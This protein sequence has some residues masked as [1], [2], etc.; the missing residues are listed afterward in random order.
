MQP[1]PSLSPIVKLTS[2][3]GPKP[4]RAVLPE[5]Q[6]D[7]LRRH[8][9]DAANLK[10]EWERERGWSGRHPVAWFRRWGV[11][12]TR[13]R[14]SDDGEWAASGH[15]G[16]AKEDEYIAFR[17]RIHPTIS[18]M[19]SAKMGGRLGPPCAAAASA[20]GSGGGNDTPL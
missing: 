19:G 5:P 18:H 6:C 16:S 7:V 15:M 8:R 14:E 2:T 17:P 20:Q 11:G 12:G 9:F 3:T 4:K 10:W 1:E 13:L